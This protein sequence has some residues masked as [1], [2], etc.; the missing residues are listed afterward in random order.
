MSDFSEEQQ[1]SITLFMEISGMH[2][3]IQYEAPSKRMPC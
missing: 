1:Q 3:G 2:I